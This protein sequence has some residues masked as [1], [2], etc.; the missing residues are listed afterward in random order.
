MSVKSVVFS[1]CLGSGLLWIWC[2]YNL[3]HHRMVYKKD[4]ECWCKEHR[5]YLAWQFSS[6]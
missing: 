6:L 5:R 1:H 2:H 3:W 4:L